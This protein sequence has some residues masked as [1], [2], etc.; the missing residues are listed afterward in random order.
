MIQENVTHLLPENIDF[1]LGALVEPVST[2]S[3]CIELTGIEANDTVVVAGPGPIGL[4]NMQ[5]AKAE[6]A[7]VIVTGTS[8]DEE[9]LRL[10]KEL[11]ADI[12]VNVQSEDGLK[13]IRSLTEGYGADVFIECSGSPK[14]VAFGIEAVRC[15]GKYTQMGVMGAD[16]TINLDR[17]ANKE[18]KLTGVKAEKFSSWERAI[19]SIKRGKVNLQKL[20]THEFGLDEWEKA[21]NVF[22]SKQ[23]LKIL[24]HP[25]D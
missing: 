19:N 20:A 8:I 24:M 1:R 11:G 6:G 16:V 9:R 5:L 12:T 18:I 7:F 17:L 4:I 15:Q 13:I 25:V 21:F 3:H 23:G 10:A 2:C 22:E 14:S